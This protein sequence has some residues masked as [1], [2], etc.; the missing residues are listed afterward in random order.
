MA[1]DAAQ[2]IAKNAHG[3]ASLAFESESIAINWLLQFLSPSYY[4]E[5]MGLGTIEMKFIRDEVL[6]DIDM[7]EH[8]FW[9]ERIGGSRRLTSCSK[10]QV[11]ESTS[12]DLHNLQGR[13]SWVSEFTRPIWVDRYAQST[14][15]FSKPLSTLAHGF[16][17]RV[18]TLDFLTCRELQARGTMIGCDGV[19]NQTQIQCWCQNPLQLL[20]GT[21]PGSGR[22]RDFGGR[23]LHCPTCDDRPA[24]SFG[25]QSTKFITTYIIPPIPPMPPPMLHPLKF[26]RTGVPAGTMEPGGGYWLVA[27]GPEPVK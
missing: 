26:T 2:G 6:R 25:P 8:R 21:R 17:F 3:A 18:V 12:G 1:K 27:T 24:G 11:Q 7:K 19:S 15:P 20:S 4:V 9:L 16:S 23:G 22:F 10:Q 13:A 14:P 5:A